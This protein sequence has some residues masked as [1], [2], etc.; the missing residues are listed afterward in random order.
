MLVL[1]IRKLILNGAVQVGKCALL[2]AEFLRVVYTLCLEHADS[3]AAFF[4]THAR[5][6]AISGRKGV[7]T[8]PRP[9]L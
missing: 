9:Q 3:R 6:W 8:K 1:P 2:E 4:H 7:L 5:S